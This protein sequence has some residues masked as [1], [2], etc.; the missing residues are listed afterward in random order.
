MVSLMFHINFR[1]PSAQ[2]LNE[3]KLCSFQP[4]MIYCIPNVSIKYYSNISGISGI[5]GGHLLGM[6]QVTDS[7]SGTYRYLLSGR[8]RKVIP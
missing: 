4:E 3:V 5:W 7:T 1:I 2:V 8:N 6:Q